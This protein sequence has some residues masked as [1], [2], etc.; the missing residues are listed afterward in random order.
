M[1]RL[2]EIDS[3]QD[4]ELKDLLIH[5]N[6]LHRLDDNRYYRLDPRDDSHV[7][8][9]I[10]RNL[11]QYIYDKVVS[12]DM[13]KALNI[14]NELKY[15]KKKEMSINLIENMKNTPYYSFIN[16]ILWM[17][18][19]HCPTDS[20]IEFLINSKDV[21]VNLDYLKSIRDFL[22]DPSNKHIIN[23]NRSRYLS[24][25]DEKELLLEA[26]FYNN[27]PIFTPPEDYQ[28][29]YDEKTGNKKF[30]NPGEETEWKQKVLSWYVAKRVGNIA[31]YYYQGI[32][33]KD[34]VN[35]CHVSRLY[36]DGFGYDH[37]GLFPMEERLYE[38]KGT[39]YEANKDSI[40]ITNNEYNVMLDCL[41]LIHSNYY[42]PRIFMDRNTISYK[43]MDLLEPR[44]D[45]TLISLT[46]N[47]VIY[48]YDHEDEKGKIFIKQ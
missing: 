46:N 17:P 1:I 15:Y 26:L 40:K 29:F 9:I 38:A 31:E 4:K 8:R 24:I 45:K 16:G 44:D 23:T 13:I 48:K 22:T 14:P 25:E 41:G 7:T 3:I 33:D 36:G 21:L 47:G 43:D 39:I 12:P 20:L 2:D 11:T 5:I 19:G 30:S 42:V 18:E 32:L 34:K 10:R 6:S 27:I 37:I 28:K 35:S